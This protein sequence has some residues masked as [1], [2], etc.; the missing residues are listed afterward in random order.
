MKTLEPNAS[1]H[2]IR[3]FAVEAE[4]SAADFAGALD[5]FG[6]EPGDAWLPAAAEF[7]ENLAGLKNELAGVQ[8]KASLP[9]AA[10][11]EFSGRVQALAAKLAGL[12]EALRGSLL[13]S[14]PPLGELPPPDVTASAVWKKYEKISAGKADRVMER[15]AVQRLARRAH[16][17]VGVFTLALPA[18]VPPVP[19]RSAA[20]RRLATRAAGTDRWALRP[21]SGRGAAT[22]A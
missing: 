19:R 16:D 8:G 4:R 11:K 1:F 22:S 2:Q 15:A 10:R 21:V 9:A 18:P 3:K 13:D 6:I 12:R 14:C 7:N 5:G 17:P 20:T